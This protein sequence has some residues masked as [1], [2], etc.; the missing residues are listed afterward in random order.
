MLWEKQT[1]LVWNE[2]IFLLLRT[3]GSTFLVNKECHCQKAALFP[4]RSPGLLQLEDFEGCSQ[5]SLK[6][7]P[8]NL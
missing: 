6:L 4:I 3:C 5:V 7:S 1:E 8:V 2:P